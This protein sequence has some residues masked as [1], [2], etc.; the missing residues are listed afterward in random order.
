M[1]VH[2]LA[3]I[4]I[5]CARLEVNHET[6]LTAYE[7]NDELHKGEVYLTSLYFIVTTVTTVGY[8]DM[9]AGTGAE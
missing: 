6:W 7:E 2:I 3:S 1:G 5:L 8:G 4:W 9:S